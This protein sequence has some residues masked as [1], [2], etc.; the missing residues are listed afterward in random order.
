M[1]ID[2]SKT[3]EELENKYWG[4]P[5]HSS[6]LVRT[7]TSLRSK[8]LQDFDAEDL[9]IM[10]GQQNNLDYLVPIA[11]ELLQED[12][13]VAGEMYRGDL[14]INLVRITPSYWLQNPI[15]KSLFLTTI[16]SQWTKIIHEEDF[17]NELLEIQQFLQGM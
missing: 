4:P 13:L 8:A 12:V 11:I 10:I 7:C 14:L 5:S 16:Q 2:R 15:E 1:T 6:Y 3:I 17:D 9:R